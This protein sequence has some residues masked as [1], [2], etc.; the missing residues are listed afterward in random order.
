MF[1]KNSLLISN[2]YIHFYIL[3]YPNVIDKI[4]RISYE[5]IMKIFNQSHV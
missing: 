5:F 4:L 2:T 1:I 3:I